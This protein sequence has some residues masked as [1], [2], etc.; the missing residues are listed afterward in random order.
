MSN[1]PELDP[2][3]HFPKR[4]MIMGILDASST[5][6][7]SFLK[8]NLHLSDSD[9]SKQMKTLHEAGY[10]DIT[11]SGHGRGSRTS[12]AATRAGRTAYANYK[13]QLGLLLAASEGLG[14][15][16]PSSARTATVSHQPTHEGG[17]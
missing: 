3:L 17:S 12:Y 9:L 1:F 7:A 8:D 6:A 4:L 2:V 14:P 13:E 5:V 11:K 15:A 16:P 10:V